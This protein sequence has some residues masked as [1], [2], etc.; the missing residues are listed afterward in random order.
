MMNYVESIAKSN[1]EERFKNILEI[2]EENQLPYEIYHNKYKNHW[3]NNIIIPINRKNSD[4]RFVFSAHYDNFDGSTAS[5]DNASGVAI[6]IKLAEFMQRME[7]NNCYDI[8]FFD[9]EEY[10]DRGSEQY[11]EHIGKDNI[12]GVINIDTCGFGDT[13]ILGPEKNLSNKAFNFITKKTLEQH[14]IQL[15]KKTPG[16]DDRSFE[17]LNIPNLSV[18]IVPAEDISSILAIIN[19]EIEGSD[20]LSIVGLQPPTFV[21]TTHNGIKDNIKYVSDFSMQITY[22]FLKHLIELQ[23]KK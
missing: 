18:G 10:E 1:K 21:E 8:I 6:L 15:I 17:I 5:N 4:K 12:V 11:I 20:P 9:R 19:C 13:I 2:L 23:N 3:V 14:P 22:K 16:S 7:L